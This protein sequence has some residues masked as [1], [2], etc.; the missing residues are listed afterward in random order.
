M[1][2]TKIRNAE[3][4]VP[5]GE[6]LVST[7]D[8][9]GNITYAN[10][11][12]CE[13]AGFTK[14]ELIGQPHN[15]IRHPDMPK[16]AFADLW[17]NLKAGNVWRGAV[18]NRAK[19]GRYYW[20]DAFVSPIYTDGKLTGY[21]SV[22]VHLAKEYK[23]RAEALYQLVN[24]AKRKV[25][26]S[27]NKHRLTKL[28]ISIGGF[29]VALYLG[30]CVS[31]YLL[32]VAPLAFYSAY[33]RELVSNPNRDAKLG[34][35]YDSVSRLVFCQ[36]A[37]DIS[38]YHLKLEQGRVRT[39]LGRV[40]DSNKAIL[41]NASSLFELSKETKQNIEREDKEISAV[42]K[43]IEAMANSISDVSANSADTLE[44]V[45]NSNI[46]CSNALRSIEITREKVESMTNEVKDS[47]RVAGD[48]VEMAGGVSNV[49]SE[50]KG[51]AEQTNLLALNAAIEAAR[52]GEQGRGF[53]VVADEVRALS[54]RT[55]QATE[56][57]QD[58]ISRIQ[59]SLEKLA[60]SMKNSEEASEVS[61]QS[62]LETE[63][64][65]ECMS[66]ALKGIAEIADET[67]SSA[68]TQSDS[69]HQI[70]ENIK[71]IRNAS[72]NN[73]SKIY[74][75]EDLANELEKSSQ[76]LQNIPVSFKQ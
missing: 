5:V 34:E 11:V 68:E 70:R 52:A 37:S 38:G 73:L 48:L 17:T 14:E 10:K 55:Q 62:T 56:D 40:V 67:A 41:N 22:R 44:K 66:T 49:M 35:E 65:V 19:D 74:S 75:L 23:D 46:D 47:S 59:S 13:I 72:T 61:L 45:S 60:E 24:G 39:I 12:F 21:Q 76:R 16:A 29:G 32:S 31:P 6:E 58:S 27:I 9:H 20:V 64:L 3:I 53:A 57:I 25:N 26:T 2:N 50:I 43:A 36:D 15:I 28:A 7:T 4:P 69:A 71:S 63:E 54:G 30:L 42:S 51:I 8:L 33:W 18:K 1:K